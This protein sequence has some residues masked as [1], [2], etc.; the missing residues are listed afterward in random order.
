MVIN[1]HAALIYSM[2]LVAAADR[3]MTEAEFE[4]MG[5]VLRHLPV[6][7]D[8]DLKEFSPIASSCVDLVNGENGLETTIERIHRALPPHL[9]ETAY[10][11][12]CDVAAADGKPVEEELQLLEMIRHRLSVD[13]LV[14]AAIERAALARHRMM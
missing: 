6:F 4:T 12:A 14:A 11:L 2:V 10:A 1:H 3:D 5:E 13:R 9:C 7:R 8:F